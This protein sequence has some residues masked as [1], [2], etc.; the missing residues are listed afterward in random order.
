M[1]WGFTNRMSKLFKEDGHCFYLAMDHGY[2]LGPTHRLENVG[3]TLL[4]LAEYVDA[5]FVPRGSL[6]YSIPPTTHLPIILRTS[7]GQSIASDDLTNENVTISINEIL[8]LNASAVGYS[9]YLG[10][11]NEHQTLMGLYDLINVCRPY[12]IPV[13]AVTAV[14]R[15]LDQKQQTRFLAMACRICA[16][17]G[18]D[19]VKTYY[20]ED[21]E[22][23]VEGCPVPV[24]I[25]GGPKTDSQLEVFKFVYDGIQ[26]GASGVNLGRNIWQDGNPPGM[27][28]AL[29]AVIHEEATP[30]E[31]FD[32]YKSI[33]SEAK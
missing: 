17:A 18:A 28:A 26:R 22:K 11:P 27:A 24:V 8:R 1:D 4:P 19:V 16:E 14:G 12:D 15:E 33:K 20:C 25:A 9:V 32:L 29:R 21:F 13:M 2:F 23:V 6:R 10:S 7:G 30:Q 3:Q 5:V 31:A